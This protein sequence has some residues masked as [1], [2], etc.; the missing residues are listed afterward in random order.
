[1]NADITVALI[2]L[3]GSALGTFS[4]IMANARLTSYR[5]QKLEEEVRK[6]NQVIERTNKLETNQAV[7]VEQIKV[8]NHRM[9][10]LEKKE[11]KFNE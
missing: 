11:E 2:G 7:F 9:E 6:H 4:G 8:I 3:S 1:M 5:I 10:D